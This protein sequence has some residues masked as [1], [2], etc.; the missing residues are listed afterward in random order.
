[1]RI[2]MSV[3]LVA[4]M[5][6]LSACNR[7]S[8]QDGQAD[9]AA[10]EAPAAAPAPAASEPAPTPTTGLWFVPA[11]LSACGAGTDVAT[12]N[13]D[14]TSMPD[15]ASVQIVVIENEGPEGMFAATGPKGS[16]D[17]GPWM[18]AGSTMALRNASDG[19]ELARASM[20]SIPCQ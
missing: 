14:V 4:C 12:V 10:V 2:L 5:A 11:A 18:R 9:T 20:G 1:M 3:S 16:K 7:P 6:L 19:K 17:T 8:P 13:W 15:V